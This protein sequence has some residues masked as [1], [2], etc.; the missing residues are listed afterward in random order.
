[1]AAV[2]RFMREGPA[3]RRKR[4]WQ[5][6][7]D[8]RTRRELNSCIDQEVP[9]L[10]GA[11]VTDLLEAPIGSARLSSLHLPM[12]DWSTFPDDAPMSSVA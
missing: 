8:V 2:T 4:V 6:V 9:F 3:Y 1:L 7:S 12:H 5:G 11:A 10:T